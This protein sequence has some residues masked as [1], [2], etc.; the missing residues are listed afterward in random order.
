MD[1]KSL[2]K[3]AKKKAGA[4]VCEL[5]RLYPEAE[6]TLSYDTPLKL[7]IAT[8]LSAQCT[9][10]RVNMVTP[11]LFERY[12]DCEAFANADV[13]ELESYI[14][15]T[16]FYHAKARNIIDCCREIIERHGGEVPDT[17]EELTALSG[18]G[19]K[20]ANLVLGDVFG[21]PSYVVDTHCSRI[22]KRLGFTESDDPAKIEQDLRELIPPEASAKFC[23]RLVD[24]G[25]A[26]CRARNPLCE[27]CT[28]KEWCAFYAGNQTVKKTEKRRK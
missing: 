3:K 22:S 17:M 21:Q 4:V 28:L 15:S 10:A 5:E 26:V 20:T 13:E 23:H 11:A 9:D 24:H 7:L 16:G 8:R 27:E 18:V 19:R 25:R 6:C 1:R 12:P 14:K 2:L